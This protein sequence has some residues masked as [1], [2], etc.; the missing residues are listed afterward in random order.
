MEGVVPREGAA[1]PGR[2]GGGAQRATSRRSARSA[3]YVSQYPRSNAK[4]SKKMNKSAQSDEYQSCRY[5]YPLNFYKDRM[6]F[7]STDFA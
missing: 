5:H 2:Q 3:Q 4:T 6:V 7:F 1:G